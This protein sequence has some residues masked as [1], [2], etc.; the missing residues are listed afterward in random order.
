MTTTV[1]SKLLYPPTNYY[2]LG[3]TTHSLI[4]SKK[5]TPSSLM[6][7][8]LVLLLFGPNTIPIVTRLLL[9]SGT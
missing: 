1:P 9:T 7:K 4:M 3:S 8:D 5:E 2:H 6:P